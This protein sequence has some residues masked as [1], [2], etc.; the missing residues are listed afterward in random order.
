[1]R[2]QASKNA[3]CERN[4]GLLGQDRMAGYED[5]AEEIVSDLLVDRRVQ[6]QAFPSPL[7]MASHLFVLALE[8]LAASDEVDRAVL[9]SPHEPGPWPL[10]HSLAGPL[11]ERGDE[12]VLRE[13]LSRPDVAAD[14]TKPAHHPGRLDSP[15]RFDRAMRF[16]DCRLVATP[17]IGR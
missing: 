17:A 2:R 1:M 3:K 6:V 15:D 13:F 12:R 5:E 8:H 4:P 14:A 16:G 11:L 10:R 7:G 9:R